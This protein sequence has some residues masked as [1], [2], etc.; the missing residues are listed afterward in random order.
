[1]TKAFRHTLRM[2]KFEHSIFA[3]PFA[4]AGAWVAAGGPPPWLDLGLIVLAAVSAR[5][6]AMAFNRLLDRKYDATN[7]RT[8]QREL[9]TGVLPLSY[10]LGFTL[11]CSVVFVLASSLLAPL[12]GWLSFPVLLILLGYSR[13]KKIGWFCHLGLGLALA[14]AP[15]GAWLAVE[16]SWT[17]EWPIPVWI[18]VGVMFWVAGFD[19]LYAIQDMAH[20]RKEGLHSF[21]ARFGMRPTLCASA[22]CFALA[23]AAWIY[24]GALLVAGL[25]YGLGCAVVGILLFFEH[26]LL[27]V[28]QAQRIPMVFFRVNSWVGVLYF[29]ALWLDLFASNLE[30]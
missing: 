10:V 1:M 6:A 28:G 2:I 12:C 30:G 24:V 25:W 15:M 7:P 29:A 18:G 19:L 8:A 26:W 3:L 11:V 23:L 9:V 21:P 27:R 22:A 13:L 5:S 20:D 4:F 16:K 17:A 14:C